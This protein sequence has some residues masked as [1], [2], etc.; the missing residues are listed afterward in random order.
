MNNEFCPN[1]GAKLEEGELFC[2]N[3]GFNVASLNEKNTTADDNTDS[4][5]V[6]DSIND[7]ET[8]NHMNRISSND[9][10]TQSV[11]SGIK[12]TSNISRRA[13]KNAKANNKRNKIIAIIVLVLFILGVGGYKWGTHYY[14]KSATLDRAMNAL[15]NDSNTDSYFYSNSNKIKINDSTM[16]PLSRFVNKNRDNY[17][18]IRNGLKNAGA[19]PDG[20]LIYQKSGKKWLFFPNYQIKVSPIHPTVTTNHDGSVVKLNNKTLGKANADEDFSLGYLIPGT[21]DVNVSNNFKG[22]NLVNDQKIFLF[23]NS[24]LDVPLTTISFKVNAGPNADVYV[25][26]KKIG[27]TSKSGSLNVSELPYASD[28][29]MY[30]IIHVSGKD[31]RSKKYDLSTSDD[32][33][34]V[35]LEYPGVIS[36]DGAQKLLQDYLNDISNGASDSDA[37]L[38]ESSYFVNGNDNKDNQ[39]FINWAK[40]QYKNKDIDTVEIEPKVTAVLP[41]GGDSLV[42]GT[43]KYTF[44][45]AGAKDDTDHVQV[46]KFKSEMKPSGPSGGELIMK[47]LKANDKIKDYDKASDDD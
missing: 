3:C 32:G 13:S 6:N 27:T 39:G 14:S 37:D 44:V 30:S 22:K 45:G 21:Y 8:D 34:Q 24:N 28:L 9:N 25:N 5:Q 38:D 15:S 7:S 35:D 26:E 36:S 29:S 11:S 18:S 19:S 23:E 31:T 12:A 20:N 46:Y 41:N 17:N 42:L 43:I 10:N 33:S 16:A 4:N 2:P 1:C 47:S 40:M